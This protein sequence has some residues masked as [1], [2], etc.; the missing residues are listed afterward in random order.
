MRQLLCVLL[1]VV[2]GTSSAEPHRPLGSSHQ[3]DLLTHRVLTAIVAGDLDRASLSAALLAERFPKFALGQL[4][5]GELQAAHTSTGLM[6]EGQQAFSA[7]LIDLLLEA[8]T[9]LSQATMAAPQPALALSNSQ[10]IDDTLTTSARDG[11]WRPAELVQVGK[12]IDTVVVAELE[13]SLLYVFDT[14]GEHPKLVTQHYIS[15]GSAG[16]GKQVE[17]D[18]KT[19]LGI[20]DIR[21]YRSG[22]WLPDLYGSGALVLN[23]PNLLDQHLGRTGSG[24]WLHGVPHNRMS[25]SPRSSEGCVTMAN[26]YFLELRHLVDLESTQVVL[27]DHLTWVAGNTQIPDRTRFRQLFE[28]YRDAWVNQDAKDLRAVYADSALP[29][30]A[31]QKAAPQAATQRVAAN[32]TEAPHTPP[33]SRDPVALAAV[34]ASSISILH[35]PDLDADKTPQHVVTSFAV[36][37]AAPHT[38]TLYW[39]Q[40]ATG[41]WRIIQ[42]TAVPEGI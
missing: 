2:A 18:L 34:P 29:S 28:Q 36:S 26:D 33:S 1:L 6:I 14:R 17:G 27:T 24:I 39:Q 41:E 11:M 37:G 5:H 7:E 32:V 22:R 9:R 20:Y 12:H 16:Y 38:V 30:F 8:Q 35:N 40:S 15:S 42:E 21:L 25:R 3:L 23:Y 13:R 31:L 4:L 10:V 19:P